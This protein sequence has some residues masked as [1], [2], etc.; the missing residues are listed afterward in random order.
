MQLHEI[1]EH[2]TKIWISDDMRA[3]YQA[4]WFRAKPLT[5]SGNWKSGRESVARFSVGERG[6]VLRHYYRGGMQMWQSLG[7]STVLPS[8]ISSYASK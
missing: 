1:S 8:D 4:E 5:V 7:L 2:N 6:M 3:E